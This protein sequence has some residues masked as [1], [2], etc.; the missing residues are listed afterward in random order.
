MTSLLIGD[1]LGRLV[2]AQVESARVI[3]EKRVERFRPYAQGKCGLQD[4]SSTVEGTGRFYF[5][6]SLELPLQNIQHSGQRYIGVCSRRIGGWGWKFCKQQC[7]IPRLIQ[8][9]SICFFWFSQCLVRASSFRTTISLSISGRSSAAAS[10]RRRCASAT[11][12]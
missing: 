11:A 5:L 8:R 2:V 6:R 12:R 7:Q 10:Q 1:T 3:R 9:S 4:R